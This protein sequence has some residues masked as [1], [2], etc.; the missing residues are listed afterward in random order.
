MNVL[1]NQ[2][3]RTEVEVNE[4]TG[5][6]HEGQSLEVEYRAAIASE[7][8]EEGKA[9]GEFRD[10]QDGET[11]EIRSLFNKVSLND[12]LNPAKAGNG[13]SGASMELNAALNS[14]TVGANGGV[15]VPFDLLETRA[16]TD[17]ANND[18]SE[19]QRP[20]LQRLFGPGI[21]DYLGVRLDSVPS[22]R[23]EWPLVSSGVAPA[24]TKETVAGATPAEMVFVY[25]N[26]KPKKLVGSYEYSHE[27]SAVVPEI[28]QA[29]RRDLAT[30]S[31]RKCLI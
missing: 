23:T 5:I 17:T 30:R 12:Y 2:E 18:G 22:G 16:W 24:Q 8:E 7:G 13:L 9:R 25:A 1:L 3:T 21:F 19:S 4:L 10:K 20:I 26:L 11:A 31:S 14:P 27:V 29:S 28:E 6:D 15:C